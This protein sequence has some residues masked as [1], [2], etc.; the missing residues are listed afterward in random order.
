MSP[1]D[2]TYHRDKYSKEEEDSI[3]AHP[4]ESHNNKTAEHPTLNDTNNVGT[5]QDL[6]ARAMEMPGNPISQE[7]R[8][9]VPPPKEPK[10]STQ[11]ASAKNAFN[12]MKKSFK[13]RER[14]RDR[15]RERERERQGTRDVHYPPNDPEHTRDQDRHIKVLEKAVQERDVHIRDLEELA[16][17]YRSRLQ[18][19]EMLKQELS[20]IRQNLRLDD[21]DEPW[22]IAKNFEEINKNIDN[23]SVK[24]KDQ[25][26]D[27]NARRELTIS[28]L[29]GQLI[30]CQRYEV[31]VPTKAA[32]PIGPDEFIE[33]GCRAMLNGLLVKTVLN[34]R[35]M[36]PDWDD[37]AND[38]CYKMFK[39]VQA[40]EAQ[41][42]AGRWRI[43]TFK[44]IPGD[45]KG[46]CENEAKR[47][48]DTVLV[49]FC[50]R[51]YRT[52]ACLAAMRLVA[53]DIVALLNQAYSWNHRT[54]STVL[55]LDFEAVY[56]PPGSQFSQLSA[57]LEESEAKSGTPEAVLFTSELGLI[58]YKVIG[59]GNQQR[60]CQ[61][62][63]LV[64]GENYFRP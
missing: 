47:F 21:E 52:E 35:V 12:K 16:Q 53:P 59:D 23:I 55:M 32:H 10:H 37:L 24:L 2:G 58:S 33:L 64:L 57:R 38:V 30:I 60:V 49:P 41:V 4:Q 11:P 29:V 27:A 6:Q 18:E 31:A 46:Y 42:N 20:S 28:D 19:G 15:D 54:R 45:A 36:N 22:V 40:K 13:A 44:T 51:A 5:I 63:A 34:R 48:C 1:P 9:P 26:C 17:Q 61:L 39:G 43:S 25:L 50:K 8:G 3:T 56:Y 14:E 62:K 7:P